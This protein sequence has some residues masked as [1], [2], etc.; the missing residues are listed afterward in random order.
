MINFGPRAG[1]VKWMDVEASGTDI[2]GHSQVKI[3]LQVF[4]RQRHEE[5]AIN[6]VPR[7]GLVRID[8]KSERFRLADPGRETSIRIW[9]RPSRQKPVPDPD[10]TLNKPGSINKFGPDPNLTL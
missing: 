6:F 5:K 9:I 7:T 1:F 2:L 10:P 8:F 3:K 4:I